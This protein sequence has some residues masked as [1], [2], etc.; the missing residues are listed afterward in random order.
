MTN[1]WRGSLVIT[2]ASLAVLLF[3]GCGDRNA[4]ADQG[5]SA[6]GTRGA[7]GAEPKTSASATVNADPALRLRLGI[8]LAPIGRVSLGVTARGTAVVLDS[9]ALVADLADLDAARIEANAAHDAYVR[10][11]RLYRADGN[12]S[13]QARDAARA[14]D[15]IAATH[16]SALAARARL[17]WGSRLVDGTDAEAVALRA[18]IGRGDAAL[19]RAEFPDRL[20]GD[21][22]KLEYQLLGTDDSPPGSTAAVFVE[23]SR[24]AVQSMPGEG[25]LVAIRSA[26]GLTLRPGERL[27]IVAAS[28]AAASRPV[29]PSQAAF[30][31]QGQLWC[32]VTRTDTTLE[33]VPLDADNETQ[34]G[35]PLAGT[36]APD[37]RVVV[38]GAPILLSLERGAGL[39]AAQ[40]AA[41]EDD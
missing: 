36:V 37:A 34:A 29:V 28:A 16:V 24:A 40:G 18:S 12:A 13:R 3:V 22:A 1:L 41:E 32:Y 23:R 4:T 31:D 20:P 39:G 27:T 38:R 33:R 15:S 21:A 25:V 11:D 35:F 5:A 19:A 7:P 8:E 9:A 6:A 17:E 30:A 2:A 26:P 10:T 14:Q